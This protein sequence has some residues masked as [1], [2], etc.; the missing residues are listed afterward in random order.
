MAEQ[1]TYY[2]ILKFENGNYYI[3]ETK[4]L[5]VI[6]KRSMKGK[7]IYQN[8]AISDITWGERECFDYSERTLLTLRFM[9][10]HGIDKVRGGGYSEC[11]LSDASRREIDNY[12]K[13]MTSDLSYEQ[14]V[15]VFK[16]IQATNEKI[17][18]F[19]S[20]LNINYYDLL[21]IRDN[22][23]KNE[24]FLSFNTRERLTRGKKRQIFGDSNVDFYK[25]KDLTKRRKTN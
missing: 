6:E 13:H 8:G 17:G 16:N 14:Y 11:I 10:K 12:L 19:H 23:M 5:E 4:N 1:K 7:W 24:K 3:G 25:P 22:L 21:E 18:K 20:G 2:Y 9:K 15:E